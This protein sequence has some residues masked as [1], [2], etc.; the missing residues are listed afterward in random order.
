MDPRDLE[1]AWPADEPP[2]DFAE[3][4][5]ARALAER[6][7]A[8]SSR[9]LAW[10]GA[11]LAAAAA[12]ALFFAL[13]A[14]VAS[15]ELAASARAEIAIGER[16]TAVLEPGAR[17]AWRGDVVTQ[18]A[19]DVFYRVEPGAPFRVE[20][21]AGEVTVLGTCFRVQ[22]RSSA[23]ESSDMNKKGVISAAGSAALGAL[24]VVTVYEG[25][26]GIS[27][28]G[29]RVEL[30]AGQSGQLDARGARRLEGGALGE[31]ERAL[32]TEDRKDYANANDRLAGDIADLN[33]RLRLVE[34]E[35][36]ELEDELRLAL[37]A[38]DGAA[39][40]DRSEFD[41]NQED[42][43]KLA[44]DGTVKYRVPCFRPNGWTPSAD[45]LD[46]LGLSP[47]DAT[48]L[49]DAYQ[50][51]NDRVWKTIRKLCVA[52]IGKED[53]VDTLGPDTCTHVIVDM[54]RKRDREAASEAM[55]QVAEIRAGKRPPPAP[56]EASS[57]TLEAF[58]ALTGELSQFETD[59]AQS[60]GPEEA[61]RLAFS[62]EM[63]AGQ[64]TFG[65]PGPRK[66]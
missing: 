66:P 34:K 38:A 49:A 58:L 1:R 30:S 20:T 55:R 51:S 22:T 57:P 53:V 45:T 21:P 36:G 25:R 27:H 23:K 13:R 40:R 32:A 33:R 60:F 5:V 47:D 19:G 15:G 29:E 10:L 41:L 61:H 16:A 4:V 46:R 12:I 44:E 31:A 2:S 14:P 42:W 9:K 54:E 62:D 6:R 8:R 35:K 52:A 64:S 50:R 56:G 65:G 37:A 26:V 18:S 11:G 3:R 24:A 43:E 59:L 28:A 39:P 63:C 7:P 48:T 17:L